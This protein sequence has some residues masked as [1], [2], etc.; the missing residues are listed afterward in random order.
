MITTADAESVRPVRRY[1]RSAVAYQ[2]PDVPADTLDTLELLTSELVT[3]A[4]RYG[5]EPGDSLLVAVAARPGWCRIEVHD[6]RRKRPH[7]RPASDQRGR[8]R[9]LHIVQL[10]AASWGTSERPF[11][12]VVWVVVTW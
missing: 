12:K 7:L 6:T 3:N 9:G 5:S 4:V 11:G 2:V 8:G 1:V 10:L